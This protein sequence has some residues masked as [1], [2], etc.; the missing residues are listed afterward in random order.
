VPDGTAGN[1][2]ARFAGLRRG[3][4][5]ATQLWIDEVRS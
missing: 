3:I 2:H 5:A 1:L 4:F